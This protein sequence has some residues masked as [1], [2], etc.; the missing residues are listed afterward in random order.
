MA[1][2]HIV[3]SIILAVLVGFVLY[4]DRR[5]KD[6]R[7]GKLKTSTEGISINMAAGSCSKLYCKFHDDLIVTISL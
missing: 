7:R 2:V 1:T 3:I 5:S 6:L 4:V